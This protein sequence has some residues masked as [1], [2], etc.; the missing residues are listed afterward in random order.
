MYPRRKKFFFPHQK[1]FFSDAAEQQQTAAGSSST[2]SGE[3]RAADGN[4]SRWRRKQAG[5]MRSPRPY[6]QGSRFHCAPGSCRSNSSSALTARQGNEINTARKLLK[7]GFAPADLLYSESLTTSTK[8]TRGQKFSPVA[9]FVLGIDFTNNIFCASRCP[10]GQIDNRKQMLGRFRS[11]FQ[12]C[13]DVW[14]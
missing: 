8:S 12:K 10:F 9:S 4:R 5:E 14:T 1:V 6:S 11:I 13:V 2:K 3:M 7:I